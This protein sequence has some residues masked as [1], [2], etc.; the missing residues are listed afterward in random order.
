M[1]QHVADLDRV[2]DVVPVLVYQVVDLSISSALSTSP[3][4]LLL[5]SL[6]SSSSTTTSTTSSPRYLEHS[7]RKFSFDR[8]TDDAS[9]ALSS[10]SV[11]PDRRQP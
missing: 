10:R 6:L 11:R 8:E 1:R 2:I 5:P 9:L 4:L 3:R 7:E